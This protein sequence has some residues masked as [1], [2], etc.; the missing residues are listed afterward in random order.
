MHSHPCCRSCST[1]APAGHWMNSRSLTPCTLLFVATSRGPMSPSVCLNRSTVISPWSPMLQ[2]A[3]EECKEV[4][5][6][7][8]AAG[9]VR[10]CCCCCCCCCCFHC[11]CVPTQALNQSCRAG[12]PAHVTDTLTSL[13][14]HAGAPHTQHCLAAGGHASNPG[15]RLHQ[16]APAT[17]HTSIMHQLETGAYR[18]Y[19]P[20]AGQAS[21]NC[22][23]HSACR[24]ITVVHTNTAVA[25]AS[26][27]PP[28]S[29]V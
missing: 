5:V 3:A 21:L 28:A 1:H 18:W 24:G 12:P 27:P 20:R 16:A 14:C 23:L 29:L 17:A 4:M 9:G 15:A 25:Q 26:G 13:D 7:T 10:C 11:G 19:A 8:H 22:V 2:R 6:S